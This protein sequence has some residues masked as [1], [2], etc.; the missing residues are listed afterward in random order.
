MAPPTFSSPVPTPWPSVSEV[1]SALASNETQKE[2]ELNDTG[3]KSGLAIFLYIFFGFIVFV[4]IVGYGTD[5]CRGRI[6]RKEAQEAQSRT[7]GGME[8]VQGACVVV[9]NPPNQRIVA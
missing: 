1:V 5:Y 7:N 8:L 6:N 4:V 9:S 3:P 2:S